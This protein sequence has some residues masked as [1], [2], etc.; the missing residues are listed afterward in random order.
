MV[1][2][3]RKSLGIYIP[4]RSL[5]QRTHFYFHATFDSIRPSI[6]NT[7]GNTNGYEGI[8]LTCHWSVVLTFDS[9]LLAPS[10]DSACAASSSAARLRIR[11]VGS[12]D[13]VHFDTAEQSA[14]EMA[15]SPL[16]EAQDLE[17][18]LTFSVDGVSRK[19]V[20]RYETVAHAG[21]TTYG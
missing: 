19:T 2:Q 14:H 12:I 1:V 17:A 8:H 7:T 9:G 3:V 6:K 18:A 4:A 5:Q 10:G 21:H 11:R 13:S 20:L 16:Q 15:G